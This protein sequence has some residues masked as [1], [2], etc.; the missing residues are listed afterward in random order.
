MEKQREK[1]KKFH[2]KAVWAELIAMACFTLLMCVYI[3]PGSFRHSMRF[4][5][6]NP[7]LI[8][9]NVLPVAVFLL[10]LYLICSN[11]FISGGVTNLIFGLM[12]YA[13]LL[14]IDGRDDPFV[15]GDFALLREAL[16]AT[17]EYRLDMH[18]GIIALIVLSSAAMILLGVWL[19]RTEKRPVLP[20][21][22]GAVLSVAV[23]CGCFF[24]AYRDRELYAS[25]PV[26]SEYNVTGIFNELGFNYC[27]LYNFDLYAA[28][29]PDGYSQEAVE[30][31]IEEYTSDTA[32]TAEGERPQVLMVMCEAFSDLF[33]NDAFTY[34]DAE[35]PL[36]A[37]REVCA[38]PNAATGE[39][40]VPN[41]G[42]GTANTEFDVLTG[43]QTNLIKSTG[44]VS[45]MRSF[46]KDIPSAATALADCGYDSMY[47][48]PGDSWFYNRN[49]ALSHM[50]IE[51][52]IFSEAFDEETRLLD[53]AFLDVL[54]D[55]ISER[56]SGGEK[57]FTYATTIQNHQAYNYAKYDFDIPRVQTELSLSNEAEE[58]LSVYG[59]GI[60]CS[61]EMLL[62]LTERLNSLTEPYVL[63]FFGDH[64]PNLGPDYLSYRELGLDLGDGGTAGQLV[65]S[66]T[67]PFVIWVNDA[68]LAGRDASEVFSGL[69]LPAD[70]RISACFLGEIALELAGCETADPYFSFLSE[71]RRELPVIKSGIVGTMDGALVSS[72]DDEQN[73]QVSR[74]H[75]WQYYR[76]VKQ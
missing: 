44:S 15:P 8:V 65:D 7:L 55:E 2:N 18:P 10:V 6:E 68:Y 13:N 42:A 1:L 52:L 30:R 50:G 56:T 75:C 70:G 63:V 66:C 17:G 12:N 32:D 76:M 57:L 67:V 31:D 5:L 34:S 45:A 38:S 23:F 36:R 37:Y 27:F 43:M 25:F 28:E 11:S 35:H 3:S 49:S 20:R 41:F 40:V 29:K 71:L 72:P 14:K 74:L 26:S 73:A 19:G 53:T 64:L 60:K 46:F 54:W 33:E 47:L 22:I 16:Q 61:S 9:L 62:E 39:I 4:M 24:T 59:Y 58:Y 51:S 21:V 69:E 48:H